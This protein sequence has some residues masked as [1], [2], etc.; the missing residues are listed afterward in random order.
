MAYEV[1]DKKVTTV[2]VASLEVKTSSGFLVQVFG[3]NMSAGPVYVQLLDA[4]SLPDDGAVTHIVG[5]QSVVAGANF[6]FDL[7]G[8]VPF[9]DGCFVVSS[10][11]AYDKMITPAVLR[12]TV[13]YR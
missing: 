10:F 8:P 5:S 11:M 4:A 6:S 1:W 7:A 13:L 2:D 9:N 12:V 3:Q